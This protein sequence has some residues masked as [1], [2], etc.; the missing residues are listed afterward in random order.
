[1]EKVEKLEEIFVLN[2]G[3]KKMQAVFAGFTDYVSNKDERFEKLILRDE[4]SEV[5]SPEVVIKF[6]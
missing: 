5:E 2:E 1:L 3:E 6:N 4:L